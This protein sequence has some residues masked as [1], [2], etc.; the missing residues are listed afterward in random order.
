MIQGWMGLKDQLMRL[1]GL[2]PTT[3]P[4]DRPADEPPATRRTG[5]GGTSSTP[6]PSASRPA[7]AGAV[8]AGAT[9][10]ALHEDWLAALVSRVAQGEP[11]AIERVG[12]E[13]FWRRIGDLL[14]AAHSRLA[15]EWLEKFAAALGDAGAATAARATLGAQLI[16]RAVEIRVE[17]GE[18]AEALPHLEA[19]AR[20]PEHA[21]RAHF[22][23][24]EHFRRE[25]DRRRA[26]RH[27]ESVLAIDVEYPNARVRAEALRAKLGAGLP[28]AA[29]A[30]VTI[31]GLDGQG[32]ATGARYHLKRELGRGASG[33]V[34]LARDVELGRDVA[35]KLLHP[36]L[37]GP[38]L[39]RFF[40]E[41]RVAAALRHAHIVAILDLDETYRRIV[42][43]LCQGGTLADRLRAGPL[44]PAAALAR[45]AEVLSALA[46]AHRRGVVHRDLKPANLLFRRRPEA[47]ASEI[48]LCDFGV[49]HLA[50]AA[51]A[52]DSAGAVGTLLYMAPEQR[53][54]RAVPGSD[55]WAAAVI[56]HEMLTGHPPWDQAEAV[57]GAVAPARVLL[58]GRYPALRDRLGAAA[59]AEL[60]AHLG[61]L[62]APD[63]AARPPTDQAVADARRLADRLADLEE[64][65]PPP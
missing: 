18:L 12:G 43:E 7:G 1:L 58:D 4:A 20:R 26:L 42:M 32:A 29:A 36:H 54:G 2:G 48:V 33:S 55:L 63:P 15:A 47:P 8:A 59:S 39:A 5:G 44:A 24:G 17:R 51:P 50:G 34:Y 27:F 11:A 6:A 46:A 21:A 52:G 45:H 23:L 14:A 60:D 19:L 41:A 9:A 28:R 38:L 22:L 31:A 61:A 65:G 3:G 57:K 40:A 10:A 16:A 53:R 49:A 13:E 62:A 25:G 30:E 37:G 35:V 56:L 64:D